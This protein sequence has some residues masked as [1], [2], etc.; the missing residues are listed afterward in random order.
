MAQYD[1]GKKFIDKA[2]SNDGLN[3]NVSNDCFLQI[4]DNSNM[5]IFQYSVYMC[6]KS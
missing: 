2:L 5:V 6:Q 4:Y 3:R 1:Y